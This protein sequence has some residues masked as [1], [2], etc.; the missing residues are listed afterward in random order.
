M[1][2]LYPLY[3]FFSPPDLFSVGI[4]P[5]LPIQKLICNEMATMEKALLLHFGIE[6]LQCVCGHLQ[7][8]NGQVT[9]SGYL[10]HWKAMTSS[11][12]TSLCLVFEYLHGLK[13]QKHSFKSLSAGSVCCESH[14]CRVEFI[15]GVMNAPACVFFLQGIMPG[16][17]G[18]HHWHCFVSIPI[19]EK[20]AC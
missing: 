13:E 2:W 17:C 12:Y 7:G 4:L 11:S 20:S 9:V 8:W 14:Q 3:I 15:F 6:S 5:T 1:E 16:G 18:E 10:G 19:S